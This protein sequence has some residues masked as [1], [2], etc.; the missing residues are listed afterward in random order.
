[1]RAL[2]AVLVAHL[3]CLVQGAWDMQE[4]LPDSQDLW[5][6]DQGLELLQKKA[7]ASEEES[8]AEAKG[9]EQETYWPHRGHTTVVH[10]S[11]GWGGGHTTVVRHHGGYGYHHGPYGHTTVVHHSHGWYR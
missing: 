4:T 3:V 5:Q 10:H 7:A 11:H 9:S 8:V 1:M 2:T 6:E